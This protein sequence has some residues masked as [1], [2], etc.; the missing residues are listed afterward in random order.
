MLLSRGLILTVILVA[1]MALPALLPLSASASQMN[2][3]TPAPQDTWK[4]KIHPGLLDE[5][6]YTP[7]LTEVSDAA[8]RLL[9]VKRLTAIDSPPEGLARITIYFYGGQKAL[10]QIKETVYRVTSALAPGMIGIAYALAT[11]N[12]VETLAKLPF[13]LWVEPQKPITEMLTPVKP[14]E[15]TAFTGKPE[16]LQAGGFGAGS[17]YMFYSAPTLLGADKV[18]QEYGIT[19]EGVKVGVVDTGVDVGAPDLGVDKIARDEDGM[20]LLFDADMAGFVYTG[21]PTERV[22]DDTIYIPGWYQGYIVGF[23]PLLGQ[24]VLDYSAWVYA[25]NAYADA[26]FYFE[27]NVTNTTYTIPS[28]IKGNITFGLTYQFYYIY[29][30]YSYRIPFAGYVLLATPIIVV[31]VDGDGTFDGFYADIS[32]AYYLLMKA[33]ST[34][35]GGAVPEAPDSLADKSFADEPFITYGSE[36]I[37]RDF[38][39]DGV[40]DFSLGALAAAFYDYWGVFGDTYYLDWISDWEPGALVVPG[41]DTE[42]GQW[43]DILYDFHGHGTSVAHVI[44]AAGT[45][46]RPVAGLGFQGTVTMPGI[47][48]G[49]KVGGA[50]ALFNG[51]VVTAQLWLAG[52]DLVDP[53]TFTWTYTGKHQVDI[54]S[55]SWGSSWLLYTGYAS[56]ADPTGLWQAYIMAVSGTVIVHAAGNGG[57]G[58]GTV[59]MPGATPLIITVGAATDFYYRP[60]FGAALDAAYL[61]GGWGQVISWSDRGPTHFGFVKPDVTNIGSFEW[62]GTRAI[63]AA[64]DGR[65]TYDLFGGTSEATPMTSGVVALII[66]ALRQAGIDYDPFLVK[67]ILK[68]TATDM[69]YNPF[70]QGS[71]FVNAY[72]AVKTVLEGGVIAY[73]Y[74]TPHVILSLF[75][76]TFAALLGVSPSDVHTLFFSADAKDTAI[77]PGVMKLGDSKTVELKV[78]VLGGGSV[79]VSLYD[80]AFFKSETMPLAQ[81]LNV[82]GSFLA[83]MTQDYTLGVIP[84]AGFIAAEDGKVYLNLTGLPPGTRL[85]IPITDEMATADFAVLDLAIPA[86]VYFAPNPDDPYGR[87]DVGTPAIILG[88]ELSVWFDLNDNGIPDA[89]DGYWEVAMLGYDIREGPVAHLE[90]GNAQDAIMK[91]AEAAAS[92]LGLNA[93]ELASKAKLVVDLRVFANDYYGTPGYEMVPLNGGLN[94]YM[95]GDCLMIHSYPVELTVDGEASVPVTITVPESLAPG[96]YEAYLVVESDAQKILVPVSIPVAYVVDLSSGRSTFTFSGFSQP[97]LYDNYMF[98]GALDQGWRPETG[99]WRT[100][101]ILVKDPDM[102]AST[103]TVKVHWDNVNAD[104]DVGLIGPG[105]NTWGVGD[106]S[107]LTYVDAAVLGAKLTMPYIVGVYGYFDWPKPG[108][109]AFIAPLDPLRSLFTGE[110]YALYWLVIHQKF[111]DSTSERVFTVLHFGSLVGANTVTAPQGGVAS[112]TFVYYG[113]EYMPYTPTETVLGVTVIPLEGQANAPSISAEVYTGGSGSVKIYS[114]AVNASNADAGAYLAVAT[115]LSDALS[116]AVGINVGGGIA[117]PYYAPLIY[118]TVFG[119]YVQGS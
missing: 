73:S 32:T 18:W 33:L 93:T 35:T 26:D 16:P 40:V 108:M 65:Y 28:D 79:N 68:S 76:E 13:V 98:R 54:I 24:F 90:I 102:R 63:D 82:A 51:D 14:P 85:V 112:K 116:V 1:I 58:W 31:D 22:S 23:I 36:V 39:G 75:D 55:N 29:P 99:D 118:S 113:L 30:V 10:Q 4:A 45:V 43:V 5:R 67:V 74:E 69:G 92:I 104:Y 20:P 3:S 71:G 37:A 62:A 7:T 59:T 109:A 89:V 96:V 95:K 12:Q 60:F 103:L 42:G 48:K 70:S 25:Y 47:A 57:P 61:P 64:W 97:F 44:A 21:N 46:E 53:A 81:A 100:Y 119:V 110:E 52:F 2:L 9:G 83:F 111:S 114:V 80:Y 41:L 11:Q 27:I 17:G 88:P 56:D 117:L 8:K 106:F 34:L 78:K 77:Y 49:A 84:A 6:A 38:T 66:Q 91:A 107:F 105:L 15:E 94:I 50:P 115:T 101:P 72:A 87:P 86:N 19:G